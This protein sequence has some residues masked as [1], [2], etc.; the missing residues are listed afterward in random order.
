MMS[1]SRPPIKGS[2]MIIGRNP[3]EEA[4]ESDLELDKVFLQVGTRGEFEKL[5]RKACQKKNIPMVVVP[6]EKLNS[7]FRGNHQGVIAVASL[8]TYQKLEDI[9]PQAYEKSNH[10]LFILLDGI[11]DVRNFGAIARS[12]E[13]F[14]AHAMVIAK[15]GGTLITEDAIK[16]SAGALLRLPVCREQSMSQAVEYLQDSGVS[17]Y[18]ADLSATHPLDQVDFNM[19]VAIVM[20][21]EGRGVNPDLLNQIK[22]RFIIPQIGQTESLNVSVATG[23]ILY[24]INRQRHLSINL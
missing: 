7:F 24:E 3:V 20:G 12:A 1:K 5:I 16:A 6:K 19:P 8:I 11:T 15:K 2:N 17:I 9:L 23:I 14:G 13:A 4:L 22:Q 10:P 21:A 18:C